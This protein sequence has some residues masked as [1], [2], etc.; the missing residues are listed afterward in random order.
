[1]AEVDNLVKRADCLGLD[2]VIASA[3]EVKGIKQSFPNLKV[4][5]PGIRKPLDSKED[6]KR[7]ATAKEAIANGAD[8]IVVGRPIIGR[9]DYLAAAEDI[10]KV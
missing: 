1:Q 10:L 2:G 4:I 7:V 6:Q 3:N 9:E 8:Y 5:T